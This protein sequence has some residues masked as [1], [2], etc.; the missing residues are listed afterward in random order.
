MRYE[1]GK[2]RW[3]REKEKDVEEGKHRNKGGRGRRNERNVGI[4][5][6]GKQLV[7]EQRRGN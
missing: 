3:T 4:N 2:R 1:C 7:V 6:D 5:R